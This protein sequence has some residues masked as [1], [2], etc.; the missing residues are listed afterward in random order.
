MPAAPDCRPQARPARD[1]ERRGDVR[2]GRARTTAAG[3]TC[4]KRAIA[5]LRADSYS[6]EPGRT[7]S[8]SIAP[9]S[10]RQSTVIGHMRFRR[11]P[12]K[13]VNR[14]IGGRLS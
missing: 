9:C 2:G 12:T 7:T 10:A 3:R 11:C 6:G 13:P 4:S 8:P 1:G 5:G 14:C